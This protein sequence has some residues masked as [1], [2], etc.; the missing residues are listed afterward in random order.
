VRTDTEEE[1]KVNAKGSNIG[2]SFAGYPKDTKMAVVIELERLG[3]VNSPYAE[4]SFDSRYEGRS[5]EER[6]G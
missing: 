1:T 2:A 3:V 4:L 5:L 6:T